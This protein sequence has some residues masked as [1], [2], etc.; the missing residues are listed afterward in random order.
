L[1]QQLDN[2]PRPE[3]EKYTCI[4]QVIERK[5]NRFWIVDN[6]EIKCKR[7][8]W[9]NTF[10]GSLSDLISASANLIY[11]TIPRIFGRWV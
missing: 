8:C 6:R 2:P 5:N 11:Q 9:D 1:T 7:A 3:I 4:Q 10:H